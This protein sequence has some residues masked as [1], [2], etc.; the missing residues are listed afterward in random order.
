MSRP[1]AGVRHKTIIITL[2]GA[3]K[4]AKENLQSILKQLPHACK[5]AAG[6][7][8]RAAHIGGVKA[9]E[10]KAGMNTTESTLKYGHHHHHHGHHHHGGH[11]VPQV[12]P[13]LSGQLLSND[14]SQGLARRKRES[15][16]P[17]T[18]MGEANK[19]VLENT[20][21]P[22]AVMI[23]VDGGAVGHV[24]AEKIQTEEPVPAFRAS[25][26][27]GYAVIVDEGATNSRGTFPVVSVSHAS[28]GEPQPLEK[29]QIA[30]ITTG[31]PLPPGAT[32]V[33]MIENTEVQSETEDGKEEKEVE[34]LTDQVKR[35]EN[36]REVGSDVQVG[37]IILREGEEISAT[38]GE[39]GLLASVGKREVLVYQKPVVGVL[40][41]GNE[42]V[43]H[44]RPGSLHLGEVRDTNRP[45]ILAAVQG[46]GFKTVDLGIATDEQGTLE[47]NLRDAMRKVDVIVTTGGVSMG[48]LDLL[49]PT[50]ERSLGG[51]IHFGRVNMKPGLPTTFATVPF[52]SNSG[53]SETRSIFSL[54]GNPASAIVTSH[55]FVLPSLQQSCGIRPVGLPKILVTLEHEFPLV[56]ARPEYHRATVRMGK[57]GRLYATSTGGQRSSRVGSL[58]SANALICLPAREGK[59]S[60]GDQI[61]ALLMG[62]VLGF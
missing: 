56:P 29:G 23:P 21:R 34:I 7:D 27:D 53:E 4:G 59:V 45:A 40:S 14:P 44:D 50:I 49:K 25:I 12:H 3:P 11:A 20:P 15:Q 28:R 13:N 6:E 58:K 51:T 16:Y 35:G 8:S 31:A 48:D 33:V 10:L 26:V 24:L 37:D 54:P 1:V 42:I 62:K 55:L 38:G 61:E 43:P 18:P 19:L 5:Q 47:Q 60:K 41:T 36:V 57:D 39:L 2:P 52:K 9:L 32:S 22:K 17:K 30:R 46:W